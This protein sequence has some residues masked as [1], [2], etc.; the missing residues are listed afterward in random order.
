MVGLALSTGAAQAQQCDGVRAGRAAAIGGAYVGGWAV[1]ALLAPREWWQGPPGSFKLDWAAGPSPAAEQDNVLH[2][3]ASYEASQAAALAWRWACAGP[4][5]AAWLGAATAFAVGLPK[6]VVDGFHGTGFELEKNLG[7]AVGSVLPVV[8]ARWP[9][10][11]VVALKTFYWPSSE[12]LHRGPSAEP[13]TPLSDYNG[14]RFLVSI[15]PARGG[16]GPAWW[17]AWLGVALGHSTTPWITRGPGTHIWYGTLDL[18]WRGVPV[19]ASWWL[20]VATLLDQ[21]HFPAPGVKVE[22]GRTTFGLF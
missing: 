9:A 4:M 12:Y 15:N 1:T 10:T 17:P 16:V 6:K 20:T 18:E 8:H 2:V 22:R 13:T 21:V 14:M 3:V 7:N 5:T 19:K 11:R